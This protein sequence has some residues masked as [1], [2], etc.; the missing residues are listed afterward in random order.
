MYAD[1]L[2]FRDQAPEADIIVPDIFLDGPADGIALV[3][4]LRDSP[5]TRHTPIVVLAACASAGDRARAARA[6][7]DAFLVKRCLPDVLLLEVLGLFG[8]GTRYECRDG[9]GLWIVIARS[10]LV[11]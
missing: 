8:S 9:S 4:R 6:G 10:G 11:H 2:R 3:S 1:Y 5:H 7:G